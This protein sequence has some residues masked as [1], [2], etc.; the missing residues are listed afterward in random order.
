[1]SEDPC[2]QRSGLWV[3]SMLNERN[4]WSCFFHK[5]GKLGHPKI[6]YPVV[7]VPSF[8]NRHG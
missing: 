5:A 2:I 4:E 8:K 1:L 7:Y 6:W 3:C